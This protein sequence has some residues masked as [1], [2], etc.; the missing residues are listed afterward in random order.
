[1]IWVRY[2]LPAALVLAGF[3]LLAVADGSARWE[4]FG[5]CVGAG[6]AVLL[7][8]VL[9]RMGATGDDERRVEAEARDYFTEHGRWPDED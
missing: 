4:G 2:G 7:V 8:N 6:L 1:V 9:F 3:V 5:M